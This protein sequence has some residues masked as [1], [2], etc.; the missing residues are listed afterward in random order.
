MA[1]NDPISE[2]LEGAARQNAWNRREF[3]RRSASTAGIALGAASLLSPGR[4][5]AEAVRAQ[6]AVVPL[7]DAMPI[8]HFVILMME[9]RSFDH[10]F[11]WLGKTHGPD[12]VRASQ[13]ETYRDATGKKWETRHHTAVLG[14][15]A[16][17]Q[18]CG[19]GDPGHGWGAGRAQLKGGFMAD[20]SGNDEFALTYFDEGELGFIHPAAGAFT[21]YE[22]YFCS[23]LGPTW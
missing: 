15:A 11:G 16:Q 19:F 3:L 20:G 21:L 22:N 18:G 2:H 1:W 23:L 9:N 4:V 12:K 6:R 7:G 10:Y 5:L 14:E 17:W 8:D 13:H